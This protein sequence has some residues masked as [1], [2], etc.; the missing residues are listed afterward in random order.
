MKGIARLASEL[1]IS[2]GTVSRAL[3][4]KPD[5]NAETRARVLEA[6]QRIGY[7]PNASARNLA[8]GVTNSIG[9]MIELNPVT[10]SNSDNF[11]MGVFDGVQ[12]VLRLHGLELLVLPCP[13]DDDPYLYLQR[14]VARDT[15][16]AMIISATQKIDPRIDLLQRRDIPFVALG[17]SDSGREYSWIDLDV[18]GVVHQSID[19]LVA[20]GHRRIAA[21]VPVKGIN[22]TSLFHHAYRDA[23]ARNGLPYDPDLAIDTQW[24]ELGGYQM[25]DKLLATLNPPTAVLLIYE[26]MALG[27]YRRLAE[28]GKSPGRDLAVITFRDEPALRF[29]H[30]TVTCF[31]MSLHDLGVTVAE[32][33]LA[34]LRRDPAPPVQMRW[35]M[36]LKPGDSDRPL[37]AMRP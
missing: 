33:V 13:T 27:L 15:V 1:G 22:F 10:A 37:S 18:E 2:T 34:R 23:L 17:R 21:T 24:G 12:S 25:T 29:L 19:R 35:P 30:P 5:V 36:V 3:N 20:L 4:G 32:A 16:D 26:M 11:F 28:L 7:A 9:F 31:S 14:F 8:K 6:A